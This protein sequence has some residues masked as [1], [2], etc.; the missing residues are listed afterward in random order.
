M[1]SSGLDDPAGE[2]TGTR[3]ERLIGVWLARAVFTIGV[4]YAVT[5]VAGFVSLGNLNDPLRGP[6]P[7][8]R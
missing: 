6:I 5:V 3:N 8:D 2:L 4:A 7:R 1:E